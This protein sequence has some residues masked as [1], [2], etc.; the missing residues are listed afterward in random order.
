[1]AVRKGIES[2]GTQVTNTILNIS[3]YIQKNISFVTLNRPD[4]RPLGF[5]KCKTPE[6][7]VVH[8][9]QNT[10]HRAMK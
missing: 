10:L 7:N 4:K 2:A 3:T 6:M 5:R 1:M 8:C 9:E